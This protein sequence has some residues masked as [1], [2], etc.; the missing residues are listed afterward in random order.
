MTVQLKSAKPSTQM[1][2]KTASHPQAHYKYVIGAT[3]KVKHPLIEPQAQS[4]ATRQSSKRKKRSWF[5]T[6]G[7]TFLVIKIVRWI[8]PYVEWWVI[9]IGLILLML[10]TPILMIEFFIWLDNKTGGGGSYSGDSY[11]DSYDAGW[12]DSWAYHNNDHNDNLY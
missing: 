6:I 1:Y 2:P 3:T 5:A 11:D 4:E 9:D 12:F 7:T 10:L 8:W